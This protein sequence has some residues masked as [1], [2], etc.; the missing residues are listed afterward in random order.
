MLTIYT[1]KLSFSTFFPVACSKASLLPLEKWAEP[2]SQSR[3]FFVLN[4][5]FNSAVSASRVDFRFVSG[6]HSVTE[7]LCLQCSKQS[8]CYSPA[9][10]KQGPDGRRWALSWFLANIAIPARV[11]TV[12]VVTLTKLPDC[13]FVTAYMTWPFPPK[14]NTIKSQIVA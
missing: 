1:G 6:L 7:N 10:C 8:L 13:S 5:S 4:F 12:R 9:I 11:T 3:C 2:K 14:I